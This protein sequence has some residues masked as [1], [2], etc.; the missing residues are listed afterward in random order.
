MLVEQGRYIFEKNHQN[1][2]IHSSKTKICNVR[3]FSE[4]KQFFRIPWLIY[5]ND[6]FWVPPFWSD[7]RRFFD[8]SNPFWEHAECKLFIARNNGQMVGR[9]GGFI[10][11][12]L[13]KKNG[14]KIGYFGYFECINNQ[15]VAQDLFETV[16]N[17]LRQKHIDI[18]HGPINGRIEQFSGFLVQG[19]KSIPYL[20]DSYSPVYYLDFAKAYGFEKSRDLVSYHIDLTKPIP[21]SVSFTATKCL[22]QGITIRP[23]NRFNY[24]KDIRLWFTLLHEI[25]SDHYGYTPATFEEVKLVYGIKYLKYVMNPRLFLFA[26]KDNQTIGFRI[27]VPDFNIIFQRIQSKFN[28]IGLLRFLWYWPHIDRGRFIMMGIKKEYRGMQIG[29][30]LNYYTLLEMKRKRYRCAEYGWIDENNI[31]SLRAGEKIGGIPSKKYRIFEKQI[32]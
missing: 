29:S 16:E 25:F 2:V 3:T 28:L 32:V 24:K 4:F 21:E 31:A 6:E 30:A 22:E 14:K 19:H 15:Q 17:Y 27:S 9:I 20:L 23:F 13:P 18:I 8:L 11:H 5:K 12:S 10:D 26:E 7:I 1:E